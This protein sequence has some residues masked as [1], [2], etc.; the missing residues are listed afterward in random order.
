MNQTEYETVLA[1]AG[2]SRALQARGME[3]TASI[4][5]AVAVL[6]DLRKEAFDINSLM[7][8]VKSKWQGMSP[9]ARSG[10]VGGVG[11][12]AAGGLYDRLRPRERWEEEASL[13][14]TLKSMGVGGAL[15]GIGGAAYGTT[16]GEDRPDKI[17]AREDAD[18]RARLVANQ[19]EYDKMQASRDEAKKDELSTA[20]KVGGGT[21]AAGGLLAA[22]TRGA[23]MAG[24]AGP[25]AFLPYAYDIGEMAYTQ[26]DPAAREAMADK[27]QRGF[28]PTTQGNSWADYGK[29]IFN[30]QTGK[31]MLEAGSTPLRS[32][33]YG[34]K[35]LFQGNDAAAEYLEKMSPNHRMRRAQRSNR[36]PARD[37]GRHGAHSTGGGM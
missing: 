7:E 35:K 30:M 34:A 2:L 16:R 24:K 14:S 1:V 31:D 18:R 8:K 26:N 27:L 10:I 28:S 4:H 9:T 15:G 21:L 22:G 13:G 32:I 25:L 23:A 6:R 5:G 19:A 11:G 3:K 29:E 33:T 12:M 17:E 37:T 20:S 36:G